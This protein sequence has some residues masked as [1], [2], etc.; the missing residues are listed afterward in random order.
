P[1]E[2]LVVKDSGEFVIV[3]SACYKLAYPDHSVCGFGG[4]NYVLTVGQA[5]PAEATASFQLSDDFIPGQAVARLTPPQQLVAASALSE[6]QEDPGLQL[7]QFSNAAGIAAAPEKEALP[8]NIPTFRV[9]E[10][11]IDKMQTMIDI[12]NLLTSGQADFAEP[13]FIRYPQFEPD[14]PGYEFQWH[15]PLINLPAAW[16]LTM[17]NPNISVAV[18]DTGVLLGHEDLNGQLVGGYDF[19]SQLSNAGDGNGADPD[20]TD[21]GDSN[22]F[23]FSSSF[24]G[25]HVAGTVAAST[26]NDLGVAGVA[27]DVRVMPIRALG[28]FGGASSDIRNSI[29]YAAGMTGPPNCT[30]VPVNPNPAEIINMSIGGAGASGAEQAVITQAAAAGVVIVAAAGNNSTSAPFYP[31][32]YDNVIAV[33]AVTLGRELAPY[34]SFGNFVDVAAPGGDLSRNINGDIYPDG[35]LST[36]G[37]DAFGPADYVYPFFQGTS[38]AAPHVAGVIALMRSVNDDLT[39]ADIHVMLAQSKLTDGDEQTDEFGWGIINAQKSVAAALEAGGNPPADQPWLGI[40][41]RSL[42]FG[43]TLDM[44]NFNLRNNAGGEL[45][46][47][48]IVSD[49]PW[50]I[51]PAADELGD[52]TLQ[53]DRAGLPDGTYSGKLMI[54]SD[55]NDMELNVIMQVSAIVTTGNAGRLHVRLVNPL[56]EEVREV[57]VGVNGGEY[58]WEIADIPAGIYQLFAFTDSDNDNRVCDLGEA[59]G[60]YLT[61]DQPLSIEVTDAD[62]IDLDFQVGFGVAFS[63]PGSN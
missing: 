3:V 39:P 19:V 43:A 5:S 51:A 24:H 50:L 23:G 17:G 21:P 55:V 13:N 41:P 26:N 6:A 31:A 49:S 9:H 44:L 10:D 30:G 22:S 36:G 52:Y 40:T 54:S 61:T 8:D 2:T 56:T 46:V 57:E 42:N 16:D 18:I 62:V 20:P 4:T 12:E 1:V 15:Y 45:E 58:E 63:Q 11:L 33:S 37:N 25:T 27:P 34:S 29:C 60:S 7:V 38:M 59:C 53:V 28:R 14:D 47:E 32:A 35:V 48:S